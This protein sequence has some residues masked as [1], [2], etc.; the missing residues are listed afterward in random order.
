MIAAISDRALEI[1]KRRKLNIRIDLNFNL[2]SPNV[3]WTWGTCRV[4]Q[5]L[6]KLS[7]YYIKLVLLTNASS[8]TYH[9]ALV[10]TPNY[11]QIPC[12]KKLIKKE[13]NFNLDF[14]LAKCIKFQW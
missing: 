1:R 8:S 4:A 2:Y 9:L 6:F 14:Q 11:M 7:K 5:S 3:S 10:F 13:K 12:F